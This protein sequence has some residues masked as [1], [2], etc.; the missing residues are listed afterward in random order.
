MTAVKSRP[1][2]RGLPPHLVPGNPGNS[3]GK[4]GRSG[5]PPNAWK[6]FCS[7]QLAR[8]E[9]RRAIARVLA[10]PKHP[11]WVRAAQWLAEYA[12]GKPKQVVGVEGGDTP[13]EVL[14]TFREEG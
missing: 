12:E 14:V 5:R 7:D 3:G 8:K 6:Q 9:V 4:P 10:D 2:S 11:Q 13:V 1:K